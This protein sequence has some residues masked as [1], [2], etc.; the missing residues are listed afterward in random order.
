MK[1][2]KQK[3]NPND[4]RTTV[5]RQKEPDILSI[6]IRYSRDL[7][8]QPPFAEVLSGLLRAAYWPLVFTFSGLFWPGPFF[9]IFRQWIPKRCKG[10]HCVD[11]GESFPTSIYLQKWASIQPSTS[12]SKFGGKY[13]ILFTGVLSP[14]EGR[15]ATPEAAE[16]LVDLGLREGHRVRFQ[17]NTK[18]SFM[19]LC[20]CAQNRARG[21]SK[22]ELCTRG[23]GRSCK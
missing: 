5:I 9:P 6:F 14:L 19:L 7:S 11:L 12:P 21:F 3:G 4:L 16:N 15:C 10:V 20:L 18:E 1:K 2:K 8:L 17:Y 22:H 23:Y 13:S